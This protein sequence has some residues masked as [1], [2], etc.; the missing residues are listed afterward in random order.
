M[1]LSRWLYDNDDDDYYYYYY[2]YGRSDRSRD[3]DAD[4]GSLLNAPDV[5]SVRDYVHILKIVPHSGGL[6]ST[7]P[8]LRPLPSNSVSS[9]MVSCCIQNITD[10]RS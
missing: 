6:A 3:T 1:R 8:L 2:Y 10:N 9:L 4:G 5:G 7:A